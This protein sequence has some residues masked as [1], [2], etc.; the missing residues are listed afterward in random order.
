[1]ALNHPHQD[2]PEGRMARHRH[3]FTIGGADA[4]RE[5]LNKLM[6]WS[7]RQ[8]RRQRLLKALERAAQGY[9]GAHQ[10]EL[11]AFFHGLLTGYAVAL[12]LW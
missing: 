4:V 1:M 7:P 3:P 9:N 11:Q 6:E 10:R 5:M 2:H 12:K 8:Q